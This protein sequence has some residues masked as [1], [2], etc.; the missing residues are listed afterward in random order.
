MVYKYPANSF[1][2]TIRQVPVIEQR[3]LTYADFARATLEDI[4]GKNILDAS[5]SYKVNTFESVWIENKGKGKFEIH[6]L[7]VTG[8]SFPPLMT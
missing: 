7:P 1:D 4:Y 6:N 8:L 3:Y 5:L 2:A